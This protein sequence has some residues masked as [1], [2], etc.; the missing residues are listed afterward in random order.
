MSEKMNP[1][2]DALIVGTVVSS[3][4]KLGVNPMLM[5]RQ[6]TSVIATAEA[7]RSD[8]IGKNLPSNIEE[9]CKICEEGFRPSQTADPD[10][11]K[12]FYSSGT[13]N[14][15]VVD[16]AYLAMADLGKSLGY[17]ACPICMQ[18]FMLAAVTRAGKIAEVENFQ[19]DHNGDTCTVKIKLLEK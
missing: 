2:I 9:F 1:F 17:K 13:I 19:V 16:C 15:K 7:S 12:I 5:I 10:K 3:L 11:S 14:M 18:A 8:G 4:D 6:A